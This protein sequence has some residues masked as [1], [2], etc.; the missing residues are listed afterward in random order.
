M[1]ELRQGKYLLDG[2]FVDLDELKAKGVEAKTL[3]EA[4]KG[5]MAYSIL[6]S[7]NTLPVTEKGQPLKIKFDAMA[8]H[9]ITYVGIIQTAKA[10]DRKS[11]V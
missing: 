1:I 7:H 11:V 8:S 9:D 3:E 4:Y 5:T 10:R 2:K 6:K